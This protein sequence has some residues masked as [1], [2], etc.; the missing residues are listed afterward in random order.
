MAFKIGDTVMINK[1]VKGIL[2]QD[3]V[4]AVCYNS[5]KNKFYHFSLYDKKGKVICKFLL[6]E[7]V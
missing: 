2:L 4:D 6:I 3:G 5:I 1:Y 7:R